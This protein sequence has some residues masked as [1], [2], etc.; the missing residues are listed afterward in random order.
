MIARQTLLAVT[1]GTTV[2]VVVASLGFVS[3]GRF[4]VEDKKLFEESPS[5]PR[6]ADDESL[7]Q[8]ALSPNVPFIS[9]IKHLSALARVRP[10]PKVM[11]FR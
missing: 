7:P 2:A 5:R 9:F 1:P 3:G 6:G 4:S 8:S 10:T 11:G